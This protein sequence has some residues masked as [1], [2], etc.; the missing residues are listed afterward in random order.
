[1]NELFYNLLDILSC[2][3]VG[4]VCAVAGVALVIM[5]ACA[6]DIARE[7]KEDEHGA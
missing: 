2:L 4:C 1:M 5:I 7:T 6:V 3:A